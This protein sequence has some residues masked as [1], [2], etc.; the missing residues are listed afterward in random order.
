M[1]ITT[2]RTARA[3]KD[4][5]ELLGYR[6]G[7]FDTLAAY[8]AKHQQVTLPYAEGVVEQ[9]LVWFKAC[10]D[11]PTVRLGMSESVDHGWHAFLL[12]SQEYAEFC[13]R[14]FGTYFHHVPPRPG[15]SMTEQEMAATLPALYA[16]GYPVDESHWNGV[17]YGCCPPDPCTRAK[18]ENKPDA[19]TAATNCR[20][21]TGAPPPGAFATARV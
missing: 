15:Q 16:T 13:E 1:I 3:V 7:L 6:P 21:G 18:P 20:G 19:T 11:N 4:P 5:R 14:M 12:H 8:V 9:T 10:A 17:A 2:D